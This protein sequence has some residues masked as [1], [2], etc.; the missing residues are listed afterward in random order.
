MG[1]F[2][3][4]L[5][6]DGSRED[7]Q[8]IVERH[9]AG[10]PLRF[11]RCSHGGV[12]ATR[13]AAL[14]N[15]DGEFVLITDDDCRP[16]PG[17]LRAYEKAIPNFP[18][19]ALGG[20]VVNLLAHD[21]CAEA[22]QTAI[23]YVTQAWNSSPAGPVFFTGSNILLPRAGLLEIGGFDRSWTCR[24]GED[25]DLCR[26]WAEAG[27][28]MAFVPDAVMG[29]AHGLDFFKFLR[30]HFHYG[31]GRWWGERRRRMRDAGA[32]GWSGAGFYLGL[33]TSPFR[34]FPPGKAAV[35]MALLACAQAATAAGSLQA[36]F[37]SRL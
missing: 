11:L 3:I 30:Q 9:T 10:L 32:P 34:S 29:H 14:E 16:Q 15:S 24:T 6:D 25:R 2:E 35:V 17:L 26:R 36:R 23:T 21:L 8:A 13:Q 12:S 22:T 1:G 28:R 4:V 31:Q 7:P 5:A 19:S 37:A 33:L 27:L 20:P 18:D